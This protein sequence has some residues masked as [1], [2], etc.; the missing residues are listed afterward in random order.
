MKIFRSHYEHICITGM[1]I[2]QY[3]RA[4]KFQITQVINLH[5]Y[6]FKVFILL[7]NLKGSEY[8]IS[9]HLRED[10]TN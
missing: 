10:A 6:D 2:Y 3:C 7:W 8:Q 4:E 5:T 9:I 1:N